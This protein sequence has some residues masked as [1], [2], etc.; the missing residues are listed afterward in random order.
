MEKEIPPTGLT[1]GKAKEW[2]QENFPKYTMKKTSVMHYGEDEWDVKCRGDV[3]DNFA[4][5]RNFRLYTKG[6][7]DDS[8]ARWEKTQ[9]PT[10]TEPGTPEISFARRLDVYIK[11]KTEDKTI[12][13]GF[14]VQIS[15]STKKALCNVIMPDKTDKTLLVSEDP[16]GKFSF[17][18]L[19]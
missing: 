15:E 5:N 9:G 16:E 2:L 4:Q 18:V 12:K 11:A 6:T 8:Y 3:D 10:L 17:E 1:L 7:D 14:V 19:E 13:F